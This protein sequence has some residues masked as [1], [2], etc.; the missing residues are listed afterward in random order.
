MTALYETA[1]PTQTGRPAQRHRRHHRPRPGRRKLQP[2]LA[3]HPHV[4]NRLYISMV[5][6][7]ETGGLLAE[8]LDRLAGFLEA[9]AR[10]RKKIKSAMTYPVAVISIAI[11]ITTFLIVKVVPV[12]AE[13]FK[14]FGKPLPAPTQFLVDLSDFMRNDWYYFI[15]V[16]RRRV[17][18]HQVFPQDQDRATNSG[19]A[20]SSSCP[21][22]ARCIHKICHEPLRAH[23]LRSSSARACRSS[24][25]S[26]SSAA[27]RATRSSSR[28]HQGRQ[29]RRGKGRQPLAWPCPR[30]RS[31]RR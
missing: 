15:G 16:R 9:S 25:R 12:F 29:R 4:F 13:I 22:S 27:A 21:S 19:T 28:L 8:I 26:K 23:L 2:A 6:A 7:G 31:S 1:D 20:G 30:R 3:K 24:K 11:L 14:D 18:R 5:K 10:L 17:L